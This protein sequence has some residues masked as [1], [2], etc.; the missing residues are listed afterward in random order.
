MQEQIARQ[1]EA[2]TKLRTVSENYENHYALIEN[3]VEKYVPIQIQQTISENLQYCMTD[4]MRKQFAPFEKKRTGELH[5][6]ILQDDGIPKLA[7]TLKQIRVNLD[8]YNYGMHTAPGV[9]TDAVKP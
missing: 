3:F 2:H 5:E 6:V 1:A 8:T 7:E 4:Q 9:A